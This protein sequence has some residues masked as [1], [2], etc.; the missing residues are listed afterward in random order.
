MFDDALVMI[1]PFFN[2][3]QGWAGQAL[4]HLAYRVVRENF[5]SLSVEEIH[6]LVVAAHR[7]YLARHPASVDPSRFDTVHHSQ[8]PNAVIFDASTPNRRPVR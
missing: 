8:H 1:E 6:A 3:T 7:L 5:P 2:P 4:E